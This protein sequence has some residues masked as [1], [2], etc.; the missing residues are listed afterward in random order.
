MSKASE[1][2]LFNE[3]SDYQVMH[4]I[5]RDLTKVS[6]KLEGMTKSKIK[7]VKDLATVSEKVVD[8]L[9]SDIFKLPEN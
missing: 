2:I 3:V 7:E 8:R 6:S 4:S 5:R 9:R 1:I